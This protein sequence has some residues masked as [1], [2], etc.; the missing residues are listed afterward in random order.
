MS[1]PEDI[2]AA[3]HHR[4]QHEAGTGFGGGWLN[5]ILRPWHFT[6]FPDV[7]RGGHG[8]WFILALAPWG[9]WQIRRHVYAPRYL[10]WAACLTLLWFQTQ[11]NAR[12]VIHVIALFTAI[13]AVVVTPALRHAGQWSARSSS[14]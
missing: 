4:I 14:F 5:L 2:T 11:Q 8:T 7:F 1:W 10:F 12:F 13:S 6:F 3:F 9:C